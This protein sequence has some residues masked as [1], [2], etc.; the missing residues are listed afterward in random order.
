[1]TDKKK[2]ESNIRKFDLTGEWRFRLGKPNHIESPVNE[3]PE[4]WM[5]AEVP[6]TVHTD[7][8]ALKKIP[9]PFFGDNEYKVQWVGEADWEYCRTFNISRDYLEQQSI[10]LI[11]EG[12]DTL[13]TIFINDKE[14]GKTRNMFITHGFPVKKFLKP[15][16]NEIRIYFDSPLVYTREMEKQYG[17]LTETRHSHRM[18]LR[19]AQYS[20]GWDWGPM[21]PTSG[22]WR[23]IYLEAF[24]SIR[25]KDVSVRTVSCTAG[26]AQLEIEGVIEKGKDKGV[27][28]NARLD[29]GEETIFA[30]A[31]PEGHRVRF[32]LSVA[33]PRLWW[34]NGW[35]EPF[36]YDFYFS[37]LS[38]GKVIDE[39]HFKY[40]IRTTELRLSDDKGENSFRILVNGKPVF[41]RGA[42]WIPADSFI[43]RITHE[44]YRTLL[45]M[46][47][48]SG[49][50]MLRVWGG[51]IYEDPYFYQL[52]DE[53]GIMVWQ[54]FMFACGA[55]PEIKDF[56]QQVEEEAESVIK[57]L[58]NHPSIVI[59]CGNNENEWIYYR[60]QNDSPENMSG[61]KIFHNMLPE[62]CEKLDPTRPYWPSTPW[63]GDDPN[64]EDMGN[65]HSWDIWSRWVDFT[66]V[67]NDHGKFISEFG[68]QA[69][70][71]VETMDS[72]L[73]SEDRNPE[74]EIFSKHQKQE[75]G[76]ERLFRFLAAHQKVT[77][78]Y[79]PF[80]YAC[81]VNQAEALKTCIEHWRSRKFNTAGALIWQ[82][83]DCWPGLSWSMIDSSLK[84]KASYFYSKEFFKP[85]LLRFEETENYL[86]LHVINDTLKR[87]CGE[88][89]INIFTFSGEEKDE[90]EVT[91]NVPE[92]S[93]SRIPVFDRE[94]IDRLDKK[95]VYIKAL[96]ITDTGE[97]LYSKYIF[98]RYKWMD[99]PEGEIR[100]EIIK[101]SSKGVYIRC[102]SKT[103]LKSVYLHL[104]GWSFS[105]NFFDMEP[106]RPKEL[107]A[108]N[109]VGSKS[110]VNDLVF[111]SVGHYAPRMVL[112]NTRG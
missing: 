37:V 52:C 92:N 77:T 80:I 47:R 63:G 30:E 85:I 70:A 32:S 31:I 110:I 96:M 43:P 91:V 81:Q 17:K 83:N 39:K 57:E 59:W 111:Y 93:F 58:R 72:C 50:N 55:Y 82:L 29:N 8:M 95:R 26:A 64:S 101:K 36:L 89:R 25:I 33:D 16:E 53:M 105:D 41:C 48:D 24:D 1:M 71:S 90:K 5:K 67:I 94:E 98:L 18:Y 97:S 108:E 100:A 88:L 4:Q 2:P 40:G 9:D 42:D 46:S 106:D 69:P 104:P 54:D 49:M 38:G 75:E 28:C 34:P 79:V 22:I 103:F 73:K 56:L 65:R 11:C 35:G 12:L 15:G 78:E 84:P 74:G 3:N 51:G 21:L 6:G 20:F 7:L 102:K 68:F 76:N 14:V 62:I 61:F 45:E 86:V 107:I 23:S 109:H 27:T 19:K 99:F 112:W 66:E 10:D 60:E 44:K 13:S 87:L